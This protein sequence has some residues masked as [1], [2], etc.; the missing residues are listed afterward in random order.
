MWMS[1]GMITAL[2]IEEKAR[3]E[4][5]LEEAFEVVDPIASTKS[6]S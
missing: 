4:E 6:V 3:T 1:L 5:D 2:P